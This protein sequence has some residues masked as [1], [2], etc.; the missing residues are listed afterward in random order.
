MKTHTIHRPQWISAP[1]EKVFSFFCEARNLDRITP[2]ELR[3]KLLGQSHLE[4]RAGTLI[5]YELAWHGL[6][7][8]WRSRIEEWRP[9]TLFI[10]VQL[11]G[12]YRFWRHT[13]SFEARDG[14]T[15]MRDTVEFAVPFG[16]LG[17]LYVG[18]LARRD[19]DRIFDYRAQQISLLFPA[20]RVA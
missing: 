4:L 11:K 10:D 6:P 5:D 3:F 19:V 7:M 18:W 15:L 8:R 14:G 2:P 13:H 16:A 20:E 17:D 1:L 9:P 12:P